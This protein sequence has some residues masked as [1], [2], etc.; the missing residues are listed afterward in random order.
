VSEAIKAI[1][2]ATGVE[3]TLYGLFLPPKDKEPGIWLK[4]DYPLDFYDLED[5][6]PPSRNSVMVKTLGF[7]PQ[8]PPKELQTKEGSI[9]GNVTCLLLLMMINQ[10]YSFNNISKGVC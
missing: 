10:L 7:N 4:D 9:I 3:D 5:V 2:K 1:A 6:N 8:T